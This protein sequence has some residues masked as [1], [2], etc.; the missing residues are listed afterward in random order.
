METIFL[1]GKLAKSSRNLRGVRD[2]ARFNS[3][4]TIAIN[5]LPTGGGELLVG[6]DNWAKYSTVFA[7]FSILKNWIRKWKSADGAK[8]LVNGKAAGTVGKGNPFLSQKIDERVLNASMP[9]RGGARL[10]RVS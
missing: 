1:N 5:Q 3:I 9:V 8:L 10:G 4:D 7:D 2:Y 6:F